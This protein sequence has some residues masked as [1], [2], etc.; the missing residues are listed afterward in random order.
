M[1]ST[2]LSL[3]TRSLANAVS[4]YYRAPSQH[5]QRPL[6]RVIYLPVVVM[7]GLVL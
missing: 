2:H 1:T 5:P 3:H 4:G 7:K 6:P